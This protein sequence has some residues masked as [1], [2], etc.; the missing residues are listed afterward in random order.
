MKPKAPPCFGGSQTDFLWST[1]DKASKKEK[2]TRQ[3]WGKVAAA[4]ARKVVAAAARKVVALVEVEVMVVEAIAAEDI[5]EEDIAAENTVA[6]GIAAEDMMLEDTRARTLLRIIARTSS[7]RTI[8][9]TTRLALTARGEDATL[10]PDG[11]YEAD[12]DEEGD[13]ELEEKR[14]SCDQGARQ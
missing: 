9:R 5:V 11:C 14:L 4:A 6:E 10:S 12:Y 2:A 3:A 7:T 8:Q 1:E 13:E